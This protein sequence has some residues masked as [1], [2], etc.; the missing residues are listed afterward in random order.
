MLAGR[1]RFQGLILSSGCLSTHFRRVNSNLRFLLQLQEVT[2]RALEPE[3]KNRYANAR[4][5]AR[6]LEHLD[7][8]GVADRSELRAW[9]KQRTARLRKIFTYVAVALVP[10]VV[11]TLLLYFAR[12]SGDQLESASPGDAA[13]TLPLAV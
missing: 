10:I 7:R 12:F 4:D 2:Y 3:A 13:V 5:F 6:D 1:H 11:F 9:K 8:V